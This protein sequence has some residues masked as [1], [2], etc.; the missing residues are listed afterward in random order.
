MVSRLRWLAFSMYN[1][2]R[3]AYKNAILTWPYA[4]NFKEGAL[5]RASVLALVVNRWGAPSQLSKST[6]GPT[7]FT[8]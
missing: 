4:L 3:F 2:Y 1:V 8:M 5:N 7:F 6:A